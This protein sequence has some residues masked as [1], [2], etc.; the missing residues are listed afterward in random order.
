MVISCCPQVVSPG[1]LP[2]SGLTPYVFTVTVRATGRAPSDSALPVILRA[3][4]IPAVTVSIGGGGGSAINANDRLI[5]DGQ[6]APPIST[7]KTAAAAATALAALDWAFDPPLASGGPP[8]ITFIAGTDAAGTIATLRL[9]VSGGADLFL[10]GQ[11]CDELERI[12]CMGE[13]EFKE[14]G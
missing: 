3:S 5:L 10:P 8:F 9:L 11:R 7:N 12:E 2:P 14:T 6:C 1:L 4:P 13:V